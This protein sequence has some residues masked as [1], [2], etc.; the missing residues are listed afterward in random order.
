MNQL[1]RGIIKKNEKMVD[2]G[3]QETSSYAIY[4]GWSIV[5]LS[6]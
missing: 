4:Q 6:N 2:F 5:K 3:E 1:Y